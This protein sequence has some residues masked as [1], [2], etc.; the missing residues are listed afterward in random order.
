MKCSRVDP[1]RPFFSINI[2]TL[3]RKQRVSQTMT[4]ATLDF[5]E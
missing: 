2:S 5:L 4:K 1:M 3:T